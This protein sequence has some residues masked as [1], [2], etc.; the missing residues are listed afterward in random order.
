MGSAG[1]H[2]RLKWKDWE[3]V[4]AQQSFANLPNFDRDEEGDLLAVV[5]TPKGSRNK[6][7]Y[8]ED[9]K[10]FELRKVLPRWMIF[11][12]DFGFIPS[13][14]AADGDPL[15]VLLLLD[16]PAPMGCVV[17]ARAIGAI[18]AEQRQGRE[19]KALGRCGPK[20]AL[21]LVLESRRK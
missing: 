3:K 2:S 8:N 17:R 20:T 9:P 6:Y 1:R 13:T 4:G 7:A 15:D 5:E 10:V 16:D 18:E 11:P 21:N 14:K 19:F 12:Y